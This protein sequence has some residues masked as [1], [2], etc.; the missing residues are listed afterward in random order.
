MIP[1]CGN[2]FCDECKSRTRLSTRLLD[3]HALSHERNLMVIHLH[4]S[5]LTGIRTF[6]LESEEHECPDCNEKD[7]SPETLI[8]NRFLRNAV[9]NFKNETGYAKR[10]TYRPPAQSAAPSAPSA[11]QPAKA[12][13]TPPAQQSQVPP[14]SKTVQ[15]SSAAPANA[16]SQEPAEPQPANPE[17][18]SQHFPTSSGP[19]SQAS[20][21]KWQLVSL[22]RC[23][24]INHLR[25]IN[26]AERDASIDTF[27][28]Y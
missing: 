19:Q 26:R 25:E 2:S 22:F 13:E 6:L 7:V 14:Q 10:Q 3:S 18:T 23:T 1:C 17:S 20:T 9:M 27:A 8:P 28:I 11:D 16:T 5:L 4:L 21:S 15:S 24:D 12:T